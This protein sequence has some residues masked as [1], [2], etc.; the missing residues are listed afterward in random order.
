MRRLPYSTRL[1]I[2]Y[3][4]IF[5]SALLAFSIIA[6]FTVHLTL[7]AQLDSRLAATLTAVRSVPDIRKRKLVFDEDDRAQFIASLNA[8]HVNGLT[9]A[10]DGRIVLSNLARPP[11]EVVHAMTGTSARRGDLRVLGDTISYAVDPIWKDGT[12]YG[13][14]AVWAS[15]T[16]NEDAA[17]TALMALLAASTVVVAFAAI[18]GGVLIRR[19]LRPVTDLSAMM[20]EIEVSDLSERLAWDGPPD[21]LGRLCTTFDR[22]LDRLESAFERERRFTADASH[23]MRTPLS[24]MRAEIELA[25]TRDRSA[26]DYRQALERLRRETERL[27]LLTE[28]LLLTARE[29]AGEVGET[30]DLLRV[31]RDAA[32]RMASV[33]GRHEIALICDGAGATCVRADSALV[34]SALVALIDNSLRHGS[35]ATSIALTVH[36]T[37]ANGF[38]TVSDNGRGFSDGA[39]A[40]ATSRFWRDDLARSTP[41]SG[42]GLAIVRATIERFG[43][44]IELRNNGAEGAVVT[45]SLPIAKSD[46]LLE[47]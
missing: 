25:L 42:L 17:R 22:L 21:E 12:R 18:A 33:A 31:A 5:A 3:T 36:A 2:A 13:W 14:T 35:G 4:A 24:V 34:E 47:R 19:M 40:E 43:G 7:G 6:Y 20:S 16:L 27:E 39:L 37:G 1:T 32:T 38:V 10:N 9:V 41:G 29:A 26:D 44:K 11:R 28:S 45:L 30:I 46:L 23:E 15:R 8:N